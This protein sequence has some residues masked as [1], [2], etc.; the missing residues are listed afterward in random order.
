MAS[1]SGSVWYSKSHFR[2]PNHPDTLST[3]HNIAVVLSKQGNYSEALR[4]FREVLNIQKAKLGSDHPSTLLTS[5]IL[6]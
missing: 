4:I 2:S 6:K 5:V 1:L 3:R